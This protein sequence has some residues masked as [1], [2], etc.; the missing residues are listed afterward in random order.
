MQASLSYGEDG[1]VKMA[2][3]TS[4]LPGNLTVL[5]GVEEGGLAY[6][7]V[8]RHLATLAYVS[9][10][11]APAQSE[12]T[13]FPG[14]LE[15]THCRTLTGVCGALLLEMITSTHRWSGVV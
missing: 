8:S 5:Q 14:P 12:T 7:I 10:S 2:E 9:T 13:G 11:A 4:L 3:S 6:G 15:D 1:S